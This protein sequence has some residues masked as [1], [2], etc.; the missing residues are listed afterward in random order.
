M[1]V[2]GLTVPVAAGRT[3]YDGWEAWMSMSTTG[4]SDRFVLVSSWVKKPREGV[5]SGHSGN[6]LAVH[7]LFR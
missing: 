2:R 1:A 7:P 4:P 6:A 3:D 5:D